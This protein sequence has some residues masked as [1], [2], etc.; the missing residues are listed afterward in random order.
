MCFYKPLTAQILQSLLA[1][2]GS[3]MYNLPY[4]KTGNIPSPSPIW[5]SVKMKNIFVFIFVLDKCK[6]V[7]KILF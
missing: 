1:K 2:Q 5:L 6:Q 3:I 7:E 4:C